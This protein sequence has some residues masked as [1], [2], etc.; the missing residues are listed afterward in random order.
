MKHIRVKFFWFH[1][2]FLSSLTKNANIHLFTTITQSKAL[3]FISIVF[4]IRNGECVLGE[5]LRYFKH[6]TSP[7]LCRCGKDNKRCQWCTNGNSCNGI[8]MFLILLSTASLLYSYQLC[9]QNWSLLHN[10]QP[11]EVVWCISLHHCFVFYV[12][13]KAVHASWRNLAL[14]KQVWNP[15]GKWEI[16]LRKTIKKMLCI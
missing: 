16:S 9:N 3:Q 7:K 8:S 14:L 15:L 2:I 11:Q 10:I 13:P 6:F 12:Q 1:G 4:L 5:V